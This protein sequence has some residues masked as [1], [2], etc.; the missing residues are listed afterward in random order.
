MGP[1]KA[2]FERRMV[3]L[4][5]DEILPMR[6]LPDKVVASLKYR[7]IAQSVAEVGVIEPLVVVRSPGQGAFMLLDGHVRLAILKTLGQGETRCLVADD[8]EA[9]TYNKRV[10]RL[11]TIQE[12]FMIVRALERGVPE[13]KLARALD[14]D[15]KAIKRRRSLLD[16]V[17]PEVVE[18]LKDRAVNPVAFD[19]LRKMKP[20]RQIEVAELMISAGNFTSAYAKALLAATRQSDLAN[21]SKPKKVA[22]MTADQMA[23]MEREMESL[24]KD[25]KAL[26]VSYGDD[27][28]HL[29]IASGYLSRLVGNSEIE[30]YMR[31]RHP[32]IL[33]EFRAIIA[34]A[35]LDQSVG[36]PA[37]PP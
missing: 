33:D 9:F 19:A 31:G 34:A 37:E 12:H 21:A 2:A 3:V 4:R 11:A 1:V 27:V 36:G 30:R 5:L 13:E 6:K 22:G 29:V 17:A 18:L 10:N 24:T 25:F 15:V 28:L 20:L 23:R 14:V 16:G 8:D 7:R 26:E 32:E 35:S